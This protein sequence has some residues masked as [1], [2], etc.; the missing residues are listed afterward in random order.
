MI[1][2]AVQLSSAKEGGCSARDRVCSFH[3]RRQHYEIEDAYDIG[4]IQPIKGV[5]RFLS[6]TFIV[7]VAIG[8]P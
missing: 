1:G 8:M 7:L 6:I 5:Y 3:Q 4:T 2:C